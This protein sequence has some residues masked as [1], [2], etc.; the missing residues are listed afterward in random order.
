MK[1]SHRRNTS[2]VSNMCFWSIWT[3]E[4]GFKTLSE[5]LPHG[6]CISVLFLPLFLIFFLE[7]LKIKIRHKQN[8][9]N[10]FALRAES[11]FFII[12]ILITW[13]CI[14]V[15]SPYYWHTMKV[16]NIMI[17][18]NSAMGTISKPQI[19]HTFLSALFSLDF[20]SCS[21][22]QSRWYPIDNKCLKF[23]GSGSLL[24]RKSWIIS[25]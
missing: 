19:D 16:Q 1:F 6:N 12:F 25:V 24:K 14:P 7:L 17:A 2:S 22:N 13:V 15:L 8:I 3:I 18:L 23:T 4:R 9:S 20:W 10:Y 21:F 5:S 11:L